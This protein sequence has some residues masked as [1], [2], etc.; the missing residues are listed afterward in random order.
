MLEITATEFVL[1]AW[2]ILVT[3]F[4]IDA[5]RETHMA[6]RFVLHMMENDEDRERMIRDYKQQVANK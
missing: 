5:K 2:A 4:L 1:L 6:K 3:G